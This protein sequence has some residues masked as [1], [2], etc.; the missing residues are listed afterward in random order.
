VKEYI[1]RLQSKNSRERREEIKKILKELRVEY[2]IDR[3]DDWWHIGGE[4][5]IVDFGNK[6]GK[7]VVITCHYDIWIGSPGA[8]D[9]GSGVATI[10]GIIKTLKKKKVSK[11]I[12]FIFFDHEEALPWN[13][14]SYHYVR[15]HG[16]SNIE[17]MYNLEM[18]GSGN[19][20]LIWP[21][22]E[23]TIKNDYVKPIIREIKKTKIPYDYSDKLPIYLQSDHLAF[24]R[25]GFD[26]ACTITFFDNKAGLKNFMENHPV[27]ILMEYF[28][29]RTIPSK[30][31]PNILK[32]YHNR[33]DRSE[34]VK[35]ENLQT[36]K[37]IMLKAIK[38]Q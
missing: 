33:L 18:V 15:K 12:R 19:T 14:G 21:F 6:K 11:P 31:I 32:H 20:I 5:I 28:F 35:E 9:N 24:R 16:F 1:S 13:T 34:Y 38:W 2:W 25:K 8:N 10:L 27:R 29:N 7:K 26:K 22:N 30:E 36:I 37:K 3:L 4:N 23:K 17:K